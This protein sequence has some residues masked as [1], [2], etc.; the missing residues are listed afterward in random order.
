MTYLHN[1]LR[2]GLS[3]ILWIKGF[4]WQ[5][6]F[7]IEQNRENTL[8]FNN[9]ILLLL[10]HISD[11]NFY[12]P[13]CPRYQSL[14]SPL[15]KKSLSFLLKDLIPRNRAK[16]AWISSLKIIFFYSISRSILDRITHLWIILYI[17]ECVM[18][19]G[20]EY[21]R[22]ICAVNWIPR[23][24]RRCSS[25]VTYRSRVRVFSCMYLR[26]SA[27][28]LHYVYSSRIYTI[29]RIYVQFDIVR[30]KRV[31]GNLSRAATW[32][33]VRWSTGYRVLTK[34]SL[35]RNN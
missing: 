33:Y 16:S 2:S 15:F 7:D 1:S 25:Q 8:Q 19:S 24:K 5:L 10:L 27:R 29:F 20:D 21:H 18:W 35:S 17:P 23:E 34:R 6:A 30:R 32:N 26:A 4:V 9:A 13:F 28:A 22:E 12:F 14:F 3:P 31:A 11:I